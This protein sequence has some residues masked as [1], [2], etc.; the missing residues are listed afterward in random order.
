MIKIYS[1]QQDV[2]AKNLVK[3]S[4]I[5][6]FTKSQLVECSSNIDDSTI[7]IFINPRS[8][9]L[10]MIVNISKTSSKL[11]FL[12]RIPQN[13]AQLLD[14]KVKELPA[15]FADWDDCDAAPVYGF[16]ESRARISYE[17][18]PK[19]LE[20]F[21]K[22]RPL[23]RY[24][25]A[26][27]WNNLGYGHIRTDRSI[28]SI[29]CQVVPNTTKNKANHKILA[30]IKY[31][32]D[33]VSIF[34]TISNFNKSS[35]LWLNRSVGLID[36]HENRLI[37]TF[38][39]N[40]NDESKPCLPLLR[41]IPFGVA[42]MVSM[43]LDCDESIGASRPLFELYRDKNIPF[44]LAIK[45]NQ[46]V[47][48]KDKELVAEI[49][50]EGGAIL[51]H[52]VN[53]K[54]NW[55]ENFDEVKYE[56]IESRQSI[57]NENDFVDEIE[58][59]VSPFHQN[60]SYAIKA[61]DSAGYRG[62]IG[63]IIC[64]DPQYLMARAGRVSEGLDIV[65]HS[66]QCML[67]GDCLLKSIDPL[68]VNKENASITINS[69]AIFGYLDHPFSER[70]Q[71]G[72]QSESQRVSIHKQWIEYLQNKKIEFVNEINLLKYVTLLSSVELSVTGDGINVKIDDKAIG[73]YIPAY[74]YKNKINPV[75]K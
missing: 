3:L 57:L 50:N 38:I 32:D 48:R 10:D 47:G 12:G 45:T 18:L 64:N 27:E 7:H 63:G 55:G 69:S 56:A 49:I 35:I 25:F 54:C 44:S 73:D 52:S 34:A 8:Q 75:K 39:A 29:S 13:I 43:R 37:E 17:D 19:G 5:R 65:S 2:E 21:V 53:H 59:A 61:L 22:D 66:Q 46:P 6:S 26:K 71:Y 30:T 33:L 9:D 24:D 51:S 74:E 11:V 70:Y 62:F 23:L 40:Y 4:L 42:G 15:N 20:C 60:P 14:L 36:S 58:Y 31:S 28:W 16:S 1:Q 72:W 41:E 67:H 68:I